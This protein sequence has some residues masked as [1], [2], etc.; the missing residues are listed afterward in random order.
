MKKYLT[1]GFLGLGLALS[2]V[3][4]TRA[5]IDL[6]S[7]DTFMVII[8]TRS[9]V[10]IKDDLSYS[11]TRKRIS[12]RSRDEAKALLEWTKSRIDVRKQ[13]I[14]SFDVELKA[15]KK[16]RQAAQVLS[17]STQIK[18]TQQLV[19]LLNGRK[20]LREAEV[21]LSNAELDETEKAN[22]AYQF[23]LELA[24]KRTERDTLAV[25]GGDALT[26]STLNQVVYQ[27]ESKL[28]DAQQKLAASRQTT[29]AREKAL[30]DRRRVLFQSQS[31]LQGKSK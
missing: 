19:T 20:E 1:V 25:T 14:K 27:L 10:L 7:T 17:L 8:P 22:A 15:A 16:A 31:K 11:D 28:L 21:E 18:A 9:I 2:A 23:E 4:P 13:E 5:E 12:E 24:T 3:S 26:L 30:V 6:N 29:A